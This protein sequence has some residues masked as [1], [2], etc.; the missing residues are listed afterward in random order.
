[1][2]Q[3]VKNKPVSLDDMT[4]FLSLYRRELRKDAEA[5]NS[6]ND[7]MTVVYDCTSLTNTKILEAVARKF[8]LQDAIG[9]IEESINQLT[10]YVRQ[11]EHNIYMVRILWSMYIK[12]F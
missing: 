8:N 2:T 10:S 3:I 11:S 5:A 9:L 4:F 1:M 6:L 7:I 12:I